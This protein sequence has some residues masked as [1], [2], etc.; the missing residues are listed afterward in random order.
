MSR[1]I[2]RVFRHARRRTRPPTLARP[3]PAERPSP[4][5]ERRSLAWLVAGDRSRAFGRSLAVACAGAVVWAIGL[6]LAETPLMRRDALAPAIAERL[7]LEVD[8]AGSRRLGAFA[9]R[10]PTHWTVSAETRRAIRRAADDVGVD[11]G[12]LLAVA[13]L[14]SSFDPAAHAAGTTAHGLYQF[15]EDTWLR[16]VKVFGTKHGLAAFATAI[17]AAE[18]GS[19]SLPPSPMRKT[20]MQLRDDPALAA[21]MAAELA[22]DNQL[23]LERLL[24]RPVSTG[25]IYL[26]HFLGLTSAARMI[27][28]AYARPHVAAARILPAAAETNP[29]VFG[30]A[31]DPVSAGAIVARIEAYF[32]DDVPRLAST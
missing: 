32:R 13:A 9:R 24:G 26:A 10:L 28:A 18:D 20:L 15:T 22:L 23:R 19:V 27:A 11:A 2:D 6:H 14:E 31:G 8:N 16:V 12:Y 30:S 21:A 1:K 4:V 17:V 5:V 29:G 3:A 25:E 7:L